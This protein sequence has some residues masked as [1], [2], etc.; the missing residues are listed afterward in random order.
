MQR[1][2]VRLFKK[3]SLTSRSSRFASTFA[4]LATFASFATLVHALTALAPFTITTIVSEKIVFI[5]CKLGM[6]NVHSHSHMHMVHHF[7]HI[8]IHSTTIVAVHRAGDTS[9]VYHDTISD[10]VTITTAS[11]SPGIKKEL[12]VSS[13]SFSI[14]FSVIV[15]I[16][17]ELSS[18]TGLAC[19]AGKQ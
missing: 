13:N 16:P 14:G 1:I 3:M 12:S 4:S 11:A 7:P 2:C 5:T 19:D 10:P 17:D 15:M 8:Q 6:I 9:R 18:G